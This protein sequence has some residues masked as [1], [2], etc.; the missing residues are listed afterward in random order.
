MRRAP[1]VREI[2][3][4]ERLDELEQRVEFYLRRGIGPG[5]P[6]PTDLRGLVALC[7]KALD[8]RDEA[9]QKWDAAPQVECGCHPGVRWPAEQW[10]QVCP[11]SAAEAEL[12]RLRPVVEAAKAETAAEVE[13]DALHDAP[14][15]EAARP[16][17][18][19]AI[20][21]S[22]ESNTAAAEARRAA[23]AALARAES[24]EKGG[25]K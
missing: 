14:A 11:I 2:S 6:V 4:R 22:L 10:G 7:R 21:R 9:R 5:D 12:A 1:P 25:A 20:A 19:A 13:W 23:V 3:R 24:D 15:S 18:K 8:E 16:E 17:W